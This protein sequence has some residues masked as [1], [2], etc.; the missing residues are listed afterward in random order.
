[1]IWTGHIA[2]IEERKDAYFW[3]GGGGPGG[4]KPLGSVSG[5]GV[6]WH[7]LDWSGSG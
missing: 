4:K 3:G 5:R 1:M 2:R 6:G 7:E